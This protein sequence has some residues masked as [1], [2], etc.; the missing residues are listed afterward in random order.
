MVHAGILKHCRVVVTPIKVSLHDDDEMM[1][2]MM[3]LMV[4]MVTIRVVV[5]PIKVSHNDDD[6]EDD[7]D[8]GDEDGGDTD[9]GESYRK[10][11]GG[12]GRETGVGVECAGCSVV[13][14]SFVWRGKRGVV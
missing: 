7:N 1:M 12:L 11:V 13:E 3:I 6:D 2:T 5:T 14:C 10:Q 4:M 8:G 9:Q